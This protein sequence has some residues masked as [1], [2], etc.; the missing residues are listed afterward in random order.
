MAKQLSLNEMQ[1]M[2]AS[3][4]GHCISLKYKNVLTPLRWQ[5]ANGHIWEAIP[6]AIR[7]GSW[8]PFCRPD[9]GLSWQRR[10]LPPACR[11]LVGD[12]VEVLSTL[13]SDSVDLIFADPPYN[14]SNGGF[15]CHAG[16]AVSVNKGTWDKS[17]G[18]VNDV[19]FHRNWI[20]ACQRVLKPEG[21]IWIS[22]TYH[23]IYQCG[24]ILQ[25]LEFRILNDICWYKPNAAP[26]LSCRMFAA[27]HETLLW[28]RKS[29]NSKHHFNYEIMKNDD[30]RGD[31]LKK[32]RK[33]MRSVWS[34]PT[35][36][37]TEKTFGKHPTQKP[38]RL[39]ERILLACTGPDA[40]VLDP[41]IG[42]GTTGVVAR[43]LNRRFLGIDISEEYADLALRRIKAEAA[44]G[45]DYSR[46]IAR[47]ASIPKS[48]VTR[49]MKDAS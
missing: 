32:N 8:C 35:P 17:H 5:C 4:G 25:E 3:K 14:L 11:V 16:R 1:R 19:T 31:A 41:F 33:Q 39:I 10:H 34:I 29:H 42:S 18:F 13:P 40:L 38:E 7:H 15:T 21:S 2:A 45:A 46:S 36:S 23:S 9:Q 24:Y 48:K 27:S 49:A 44:Q 20:S 12:A 6:N 22:G 47:T 30:D 26:N 43:R 28:A 37:R